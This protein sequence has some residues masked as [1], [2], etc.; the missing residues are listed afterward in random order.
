M[1]KGLKK[2]KVEDTKE[3]K[4]DSSILDPQS[5]IIFSRIVGI[6]LIDYLF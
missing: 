1:L 2:T 6:I 3:N 4:A 5:N